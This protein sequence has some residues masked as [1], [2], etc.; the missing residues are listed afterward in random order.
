[1]NTLDSYVRPIGAGVL[2]AGLAMLGGCADPNTNPP[3]TSAVAEGDS[4]DAGME[5]L[6]RRFPAESLDMPADVIV[7]DPAAN[8]T[9][10][11]YF[12]DLHVHTT[13]SFDAF[14]FGT[15]ATPDDAYRFAEGEALE[16]PA[17]FE[18][19]LRAPLDF[20]AVT[21]HAQFLGGVAAAADPSTD[22]SQL[23][24]A[25]DLHN[26]NARENR[27]AD[28]LVER[29]TAFRGF[30]PQTRAGLADGSID[31]EMVNRIASSA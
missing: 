22:F 16:H 1:M 12:G 17:G 19:K 21:D 8:A 23:P 10:S 24:H 13:Y 2:A 30:I 4:A 3:A 28:G 14:A 6:P 29:V 15:V 5:A 20:Y 31:M 7:V 27:T 26:L 9:R 25:Q 18:V 11:A